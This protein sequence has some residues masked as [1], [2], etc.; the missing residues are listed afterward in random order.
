MKWITTTILAT[1]VSVLLSGSDGARNE[2]ARGTSTMDETQTGTAS[3]IFLVQANDG[4]E[5]D[6]GQ[7]RWMGRGPLDRDWPTRGGESMRRREDARRGAPPSQTMT[8]EQIEA[9]METIKEE[10]PRLYEVL[11][12]L[13]ET[14]PVVFEKLLHRARDPINRIREM[15]RHSPEAAEH[16]LEAFRVELDL[17]RLRVRWKIAQTDTERDQIRQALREQL[18]QRFDTRVKGMRQEIVKL[19]ERLARLKEDVA[20]REANK[21]AYV[22]KDLGLIL[23]GKDPEPMGPPPGQFHRGPGPRDGLGRPIR[24]EPP[25]EEE[26]LGPGPLPAD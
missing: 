8:P 5:P 21:E 25:F 6:K 20:R 11:A 12:D 24:D 7:R 17:A 15:K 1:C 3:P 18:S 14:Q 16:F 2:P 9:F 10:F 13:D 26:P 4:D 23:Q 19:E 22:D